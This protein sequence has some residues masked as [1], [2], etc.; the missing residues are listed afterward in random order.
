MAATVGTLI[1]GNPGTDFIYA[2][3]IDGKDFFLDTREI[4]KEMNDRSLS[5]PVVIY[6]LT[7]SIRSSLKDL[8]SGES[9]S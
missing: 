1:I 8:A 3:R 6:H 7:E 5:D 9:A 2:H 4:R